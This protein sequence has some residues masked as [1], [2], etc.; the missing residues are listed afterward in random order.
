MEGL[1]E[2]GFAH[3]VETWRD[4]NLVGGLYG[5]ALGGAFFGESMFSRFR[6]A[7][8][9]AMVHLVARLKWGGF[10]LLDVQFI[11]DHL[12]Q[13]G[14]VEIPTRVY[15][16]R[17]DEVLKIKAAFYRDAAPSEVEGALEELFRQSSTQT[18]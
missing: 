8:K 3:S 1:F 18:S 5:V 10:G 17:L 7:S 6:D 11:T 2:L 13:F 12:R 4:G 16:E 14:A 15:L 9:V